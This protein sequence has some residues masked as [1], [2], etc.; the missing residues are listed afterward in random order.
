MSLPQQ[1]AIPFYATSR[2]LSV[3]E[4]STPVATALTLGTAPLESD[5][6]TEVRSSMSIYVHNSRRSIHI[7][8]P[9]QSLAADHTDADTN[10][11]EANTAPKVT[12]TAVLSSETG[13]NTIGVC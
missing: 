3:S 9:H 8:H 4:S 7:P 2:E 5:D 6:G 10:L 11:L 13:D 1:P 12:S